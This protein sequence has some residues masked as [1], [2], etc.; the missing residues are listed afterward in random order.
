[1]LCTFDDDEEEEEEGLTTWLPLGGRVAGAHPGSPPTLHLGGWGTGP[2]ARLGVRSDVGLTV[3][4][5]VHVGLGRCRM[6]AEGGVGRGRYGVGVGCGRCWC[7]YVRSAFCVR[8]I[9]GS[10]CVCVWTVYTYVR[11]EDLSRYKPRTA[12]R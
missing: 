5:Q 11:E 4:G 10:V 3:L 2:A 12:L 8:S 6:R 9:H 1:V 7:G